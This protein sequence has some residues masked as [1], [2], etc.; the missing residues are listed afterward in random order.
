VNYFGH[1]LQD[2]NVD[3]DKK[4]FLGIGFGPEGVPID[5]VPLHLLGRLLPDYH[6]LVVDEFAKF[7]SHEG[8]QEVQELEET[9]DRV[10]RTFGKTNRIRCSDFMESP[11][12]KNVLEELSRT[13][14]SSEELRNIAFKATPPR[15][16]NQNHPLAYP[17]NEVACV[18]YLYSHGSRTKLG[19][20][21]EI[22][23]D[24]LVR[25]LNEN[26]K[27][28]FRGRFRGL[29]FGY[30]KP[31]FSVSGKPVV[32]YVSTERSD[33]V[34]FDDSE[35]EVVEKLTRA[36]ERTLKYFATIGYIASI[37]RGCDCNPQ[38]VQALEGRKLLDSAID[39][40]FN[41]VIRPYQNGGLK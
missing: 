31:A 27:Y 7:N 13:I 28:G 37:V 33:R 8:N 39:S 21:R 34:F 10:D 41:G 18:A 19:P 3:L 22:P 15:Y 35:Q 25:T 24:K 23:Y 12:Y 40:L 17:I 29:Q 16:R 2:T 30:T 32:P 14:E 4:T 38:I 9:L 1:L 5:I 20:D 36:D 6:L 26:G 11:D